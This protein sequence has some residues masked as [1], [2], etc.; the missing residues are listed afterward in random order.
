MRTKFSLI[1]PVVALATT[2]AGCG[3]SGPSKAQFA[4]KA[5][6]A[7]ASGNNAISTT[8][9]PTNAPQV[10]TAAGTSADTID[11]QVRALQALKLPGGKDKATMQ[12]LITAIGDVR[13]P[14]RALA[15]AAGKTDDAAM[16]K[17]AVDM[18]AK[19][20]A[21]ANWGGLGGLAQCGTQLKFGLGNMFDGVK[22]VVKATYV[23]KA[24]G[25]CR[26]A[27]RKIDAMAAPG[28]SAASFA[29]FIEGIGTIS[30][31]LLSD[32]KAL[33]VPPGDE[34]TV[35]EF[36]T[37]M[38]NLNNKFKEIV[39]AAKANNPRLATGLFDELDVANTALNAKLDAY[40]LKTCGSNA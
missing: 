20:D 10:A 32:I 21:A 15:D 35:G 24:E 3:D 22:N 11:G 8:P 29:R 9:K 31:K 30:V 4:T 23:V 37:A 7:C 25:L 1:I 13:A 28:S 36:T 12:S 33:P 16:A 39:A 17:A 27:Y 18:Q 19:A 38:D 14:V 5:D 40:G 34:G 6:A 2:L 26:D